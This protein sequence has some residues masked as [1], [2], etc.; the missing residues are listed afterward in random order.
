MSNLT[1][2]QQRV[3]GETAG[4]PYGTVRSYGEIAERIGRPKAAR[5]IGATMARNPFPIII[6]CHRVIGAKGRLGGYGG[7]VELKRRLLQLE[8]AVGFK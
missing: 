4:I 6:P 8:G 7:G 5:F 3:L 1:V 2:L